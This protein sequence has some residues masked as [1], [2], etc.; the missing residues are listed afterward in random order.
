MTNSNYQGQPINWQ[1]PQGQQQ[2]GNQR[3]EFSNMQ[4]KRKA[5]LIG[6]NYF[7]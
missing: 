2:I 5:L 3:F 6:V 1:Q 7:G 4:G